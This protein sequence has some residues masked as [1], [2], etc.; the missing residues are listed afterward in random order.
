M[1][2]AAALGADIVEADVH[3]RRGRLE[4]RHEKALGP[5]P[6]FYDKGHLYP[7]VPPPPLL[8]DLMAGLPAGPTL[9]LDLKGV[10]QVGARTLQ[11]LLAS[12][13]ATPLLVCSRW[14]PSALGFAA[15][16]WASVLLSARGHTELARL[17]RRIRAGGAP[18]GV[19]LHL[20]LLTPRLVEELHRDVPLILSWPVDDLP[21]LDRAR[22]VGIDGAITKSDEVI[23]VLVA[24]GHRDLPT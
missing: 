3:L 5:L 21:S 23:K 9:M 20:S 12:P 4:I 1:R 19:S 7:T 16:P 11:A 13:P 8:A 22:E 18:D 2:S 24:A 6:R 15:I 17:R 10:G 14:W